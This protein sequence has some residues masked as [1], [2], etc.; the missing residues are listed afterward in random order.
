MIFFKYLNR[1]FTFL[2]ANILIVAVTSPIHA[3][4]DKPPQSITQ[5]TL[6]SYPNNPNNLQHEV[7]LVVVIG[8]E[9]KEIQLK[10]EV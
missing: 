5:E 6:I 7:E 10:L 2:I 1:F 4:E 3:N 8:L 9:G